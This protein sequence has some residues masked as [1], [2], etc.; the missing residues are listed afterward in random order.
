MSQTQHYA[1]KLSA[2]VVLLVF[3][4]EATGLAGAELEAAFCG[5]A[6]LRMT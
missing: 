2:L 3:K 4:G 6:L 5:M 1:T